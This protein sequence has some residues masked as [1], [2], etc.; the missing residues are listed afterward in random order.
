MPVT[1]RLDA[2]DRIATLERRI[3]AIGDLF[4]AVPEASDLAPATLPS[5]GELQM[6]IADELADC[7]K[8]LRK[9][10][11]LAIADSGDAR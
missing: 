9:S 4:T 8:L 10:R 7:S 11:E 5:V 6:E 1:N 2:L 3:H